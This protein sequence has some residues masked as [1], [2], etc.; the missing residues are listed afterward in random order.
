MPKEEEPS[1]K[2][3]EYDRFF[4]AFYVNFK[5]G[6]FVIC[7]GNEI[8]RPVEL[9]ARI[10]IDSDSFKA[11]AKGVNLVLQKYEKQFGEIKQSTN[12]T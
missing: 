3:L 4:D 11:F 2:L 6:M 1:F 9:K 10:W 12:R 7:F 5:K 8:D